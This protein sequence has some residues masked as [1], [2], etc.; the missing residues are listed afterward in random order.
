MCGPGGR[1]RGRARRASSSDETGRRET[2]S[3][4]REALSL[5]SPDG[6]QG[7]P[8]DRAPAA[9]GQPLLESRAPG[10]CVPPACPADPQ[11][12]PSPEVTGHG[13]PEAWGSQGGAGA[14][15]GN[16]SFWKVASVFVS[17]RVSHSEIT[18]GSKTLD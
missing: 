9:R 7:R 6:Q 3:D 5:W 8:G 13:R 2:L 10:R 15:P 14:S 16:T 12:G 17:G 11:A 18:G 4:R 1:G